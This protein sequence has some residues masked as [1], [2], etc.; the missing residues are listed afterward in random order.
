MTREKLKPMIEN[1]M[2]DKDRDERELMISVRVN[3]NSV[4][5]FHISEDGRCVDEDSTQAELMI[6]NVMA[7]N[8]GL[9]PDILHIRYEAVKDCV[10]G[11]HLEESENDV[12]ADIMILTYENGVEVELGFLTI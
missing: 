11:I 3:G 9:A 4:A 8:I 5:D 1:F 12:I 7:D 6:S 10:M 2:E